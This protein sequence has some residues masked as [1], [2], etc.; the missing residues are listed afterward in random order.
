MVLEVGVGD[1]VDG[2]ALALGPLEE[3]LLP[4]GPAGRAGVRRQVVEAEVADV[5][6][7]LAVV[8]A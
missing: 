7:H 2:V 1:D 4:V 5:G 3:R 6:G 8:G